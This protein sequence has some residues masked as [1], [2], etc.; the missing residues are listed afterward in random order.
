MKKVLILLSLFIGT[1]A[2]AEPVTC[3][4]AVDMLSALVEA[5]APTD[6]VKHWLKKGLDGRV[7]AE[8]EQ[9]VYLEALQV[10]HALRGF[11]LLGNSTIGDDWPRT[12]EII[13]CD[14]E[15]LWPEN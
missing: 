13:I 14:S 15:K 2:Q 7:S 9:Q 3:Q 1:S 8:R 6:V 5:D 4:R 12:A 11:N 10:I